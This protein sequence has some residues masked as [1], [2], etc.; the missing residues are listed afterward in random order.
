MYRLYKQMNIPAR[1]AQF[2]SQLAFIL[3]FSLLALGS[4]K[5]QAS[6]DLNYKK[7]SLGVFNG[8]FDTDE[9]KSIIGVEYEYKFKPKWGAGVLYEY[10]KRAHGGDGIT[11]KIIALYYHPDTKWRFGAGYGN[12]KIGNDPNNKTLFRLGVSYDYHIGKM[13]IAPSLNFDRVDG[14]VISIYGIALIWFF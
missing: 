1:G 3:I 8:L 2:F 7:H 9:G 14:K 4:T 13:G 6:D 11:T 12:E 10:S 5:A